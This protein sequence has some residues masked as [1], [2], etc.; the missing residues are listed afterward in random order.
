MDAERLQNIEE[1]LREQVAANRSPQEM[2]ARLF[3]KSNNLAT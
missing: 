2:L 3:D 1:G